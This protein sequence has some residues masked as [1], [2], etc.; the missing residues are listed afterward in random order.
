MAFFIRSLLR[1]FVAS[2]HDLS[3]EEQRNARGKKPLADQLAKETRAVIF[4]SQDAA[5]F[6]QRVPRL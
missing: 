3:L 6:E 4:F 2:F 5:V 1:H